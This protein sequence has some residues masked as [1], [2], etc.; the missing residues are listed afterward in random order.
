MTAAAPPPSGTPWR[1][2]CCRRTAVVFAHQA[3]ARASGTAVPVTLGLS[4]KLPRRAADRAH[5]AHDLDLEVLEVR[6]SSGSGTAPPSGVLGDGGGAGVRG[7]ALSDT[8]C[9]VA[10]VDVRN[11]RNHR[12]FDALPVARQG[13]QREIGFVSPSTEAPTELMSHVRRSR[14][15]RPAAGI[16]DVH[17]HRD[18]GGPR[19][20]KAVVVA[21]APSR[22]RSRLRGTSRCSPPAFRRCTGRAASEFPA[23]T[24]D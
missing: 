4:L 12:P 16:D 23:G 5:M 9:G 17:R 19:R 10:D 3:H 11:R 22:S 18:L 24:L 8:T 1:C 6:V 21:G 20:D 7:G 15:T 2:R 13:M 14:A